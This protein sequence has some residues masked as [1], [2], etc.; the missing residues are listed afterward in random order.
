MAMSLPPVPRVAVPPISFRRRSGRARWLRRLSAA[1]VLLVAAWAGGLVWFVDRIAAIPPGDGRTT[2][3][4][5]VLTGGSGRLAAGLRLLAAERADKLFVSGVYHGV[6]VAELLRVSRRAP[7]ELE[8]CIVL[9]YRADDTVGNA[10]E[11]AAWMTAEGYRSL[12]LVTA[13]YHMP[14][15]LV[16]FHRVLPQA[17]ILPHPVA[18]SV[19]RLEEWWRWPGTTALLVREYNK[20]LVSLARAWLS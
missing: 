4:I 10:R 11:T 14:R 1:G 13:N 12:R 5:V 2:D 8:C 16:E 3:A 19:V 9:G 6:D 20:Y 7:G 15:S 18:P 17:E